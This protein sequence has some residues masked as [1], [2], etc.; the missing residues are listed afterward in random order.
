MVQ[1]VLG[2]T[3]LTFPIRSEDQRHQIAK[4]HS[5]LT[6]VGDKAEMLPLQQVFLDKKS[7]KRYGLRVLDISQPESG[8]P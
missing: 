7:L 5:I 6:F 8:E 1:K 3:L 4:P 2:T